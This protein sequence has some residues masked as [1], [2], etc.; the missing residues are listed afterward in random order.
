MTMN[1]NVRTRRPSGRNVNEAEFY[2]VSIQ[3]K[4]DRKIKPDVVISQHGEYRG[5][6]PANA[7]EGRKVTKISEVP[8]L[9]RRPEALGLTCREGP[10]RVRDHRDV[11]CSGTMT[12]M[13]I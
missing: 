2:P 4:P 3:E 11:H 8:D 7:I 5:T 10:V 12:Q 13:H 9:V 6:E 1:Q